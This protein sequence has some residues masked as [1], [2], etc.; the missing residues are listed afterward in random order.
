MLKKC[1]TRGYWDPEES[2]RAKW[3]TT[4]AAELDARNLTHDF[5]GLS[6][7]L[8]GQAQPAQFQS[9]G[10]TGYI[11]GSIYQDGGNHSISTEQIPNTEGTATTIDGNSVVVANN[12]NSEMPRFYYLPSE[13][14][15]GGLYNWYA[16]TAETGNRS[17]GNNATDSV[18][19]LG[20]KMSDDDSNKS[21]NSLLPEYVIDYD[22]LASS[23]NA[24]K[25]PLQF[26]YSG[27]YTFSTGQRAH[28]LSRGYYWTSIARSTVNSIDL[29]IFDSNNGN[30]VAPNHNSNKTYG[31]TI[32]CVK[33]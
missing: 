12:M 28:R 19:P 15:Y 3:T 30:A 10:Q 32:R 25:Q 17:T 26:V 1:V 21:Y 33:K 9:E 27:W 11:W 18:C 4:Y 2:T 23:R 29:R 24:L 16:A 5:T 8:L 6:E 31:F 7:L 14:T 22:D 13:P 20:W